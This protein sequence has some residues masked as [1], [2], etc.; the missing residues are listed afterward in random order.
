MPLTIASLLI[1]HEYLDISVED[2]TRS[3]EMKEEM[4]YH[5]ELKE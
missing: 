5:Q 1:S 2:K 3:H 4:E